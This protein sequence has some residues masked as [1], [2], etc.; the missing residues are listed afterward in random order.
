MYSSSVNS[1]PRQ[2]GGAPDSKTP[3]C[4][5]SIKD[6]MTSREAIRKIEFSETNFSEHYSN[7]KVPHLLPSS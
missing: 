1:S 5:G 4:P 6:T 3:D 2:S 7:S